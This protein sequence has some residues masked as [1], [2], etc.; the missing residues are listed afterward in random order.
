MPKKRTTTINIKDKIVI[1]VSFE[2]IFLVCVVCFF[3]ITVSSLDLESKNLFGNFVF[4]LSKPFA[5]YIAKVIQDEHINTQQAIIP[6]IN[7]ITNQENPIIYDNPQSSRKEYLLNQKAEIEAQLN[8]INIE[9]N[10]NFEGENNNFN[11][12]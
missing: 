8:D 6:Y 5:G 3:I 7:E 11:Q 1:Q 4:E 10:S 2:F 12:F 9:L